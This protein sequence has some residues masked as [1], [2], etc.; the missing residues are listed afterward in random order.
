MQCGQKTSMQY[1]RSLAK[2]LFFAVGGVTQKLIDFFNG[3]GVNAL[4]Q[5][6][7]GIFPLMQ[8]NFHGL[9][10]GE[11][12]ENSVCVYTQAVLAITPHVMTWAV[13]AIPEMEYKRVLACTSGLPKTQTGIAARLQ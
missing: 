1:A 7:R 6:V 8:A 5:C 3:G 10:V 13:L 4:Y 11:I 12:R 2:F 9:S